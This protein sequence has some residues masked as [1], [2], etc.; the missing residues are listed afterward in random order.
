MANRLPLVFYEICEEIILMCQPQQSKV[1]PKTSGISP[2]WKT[3]ESIISP[4]QDI[5]EERNQ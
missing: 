4:N 5:L 2:I 1:F 3:L